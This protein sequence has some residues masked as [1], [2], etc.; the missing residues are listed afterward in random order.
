VSVSPPPLPETLERLDARIA[1]QG[2]DR[3]D[4]LV[5]RALSYG[6]VLPQERARAPL[7]GG[8]SCGD[9]DGAPGRG[10]VRALYGAYG[11]EA[12]R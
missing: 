10:R 3:D 9:R 4:V 11:E 7:A 12:E 8:T 1:E 6:T 2:P 5:P